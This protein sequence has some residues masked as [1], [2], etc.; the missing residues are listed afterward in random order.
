MRIPL[1]FIL[2]VCLAA[3][4]AARDL[5]VSNVAGDDRRDGRRARVLQAGHGPVQT[6]SKA[7]RLAESGDRIIVENTGELYRETLSLTGNRHGASPVRPLVI[8]GGGATLDGSVPISPDAWKHHAG[9]V[10][11]YRPARMGYQQ[12]FISGRPAIRRPAQ[13]AA[14]ALPP[15]EPLQWCFTR[16]TIFFR[17][18]TGRLPAD[19]ELSCCG[20]QTGITLY[21]VQGLL[22]RDLVVQG[23]QLDGVAVHDRVR[24]TRLERITARDNGQSGVSLRG[25]SR[26][27]LDGCQFSGNGVSQLRV[28]NFARVWLYDCKLTADTAPAMQLTGGQ[29]TIDDEPFAANVFERRAPAQSP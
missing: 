3:S 17:V 10:F 19:Y 25:A 21:H 24:E 27:E 5:F 1:G 9:E 7:L 2:L 11:S 26:V 18:E 13:P 6:I 12:L 15:L 14:V 29:V 23:F 20:L 16:G 8:E 22:I 4:A 28:D